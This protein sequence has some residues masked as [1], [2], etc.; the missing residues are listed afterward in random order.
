MS[1]RFNVLIERRVLGYDPCQQDCQGDGQ[2]AGGAPEGPD[3]LSSHVRWSVG[4]IP[5]RQHVIVKGNSS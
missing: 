3:H 5:E 4:R 2:Q 1:H